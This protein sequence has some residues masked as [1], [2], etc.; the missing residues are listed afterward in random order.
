MLTF[1]PVTNF[2]NWGN[3]FSFLIKTLEKY[4]Y[5]VAGNV[6]IDIQIRSKYTEVFLYFS[7]TLYI[8][9]NLRWGWFGTIE[10]DHF[11]RI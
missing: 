9:T 5:R 2:F 7:D 6:N 1:P 4:Y 8:G 3:T 11:I 10:Q